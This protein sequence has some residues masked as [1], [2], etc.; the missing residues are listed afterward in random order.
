MAEWRGSQ[1]LPIGKKK[2]ENIKN[3]AVWYPWQ[4]WRETSKELTKQMQEALYITSTGFSRSL[5]FGSSGNSVKTTLSWQSCLS[6]VRKLVSRFSTICVCSWARQSGPLGHLE[7]P[8]W[9]QVEW[10]LSGKV[11][12][13][14]YALPED[15]NSKF[16]L[17]SWPTPIFISCSP[18]EKAVGEMG[19]DSGICSLLYFSM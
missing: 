18:R 10:P 4:G 7:K 2:G 6:Q 17:W 3:K 5:V 11:L 12:E 14:I 9:V 8:H 1:Q 16:I 13:R 15:C 19:L